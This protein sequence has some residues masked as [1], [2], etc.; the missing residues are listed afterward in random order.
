[1]SLFSPFPWAQCWTQYLRAW[2]LNLWGLNLSLHTKNVHVNLIIVKQFLH[3]FGVC[4]CVLPSVFLLYFSLCISLRKELSFDPISCPPPPLLFGLV[5][6]S[7]PLACR[8]NS[9]G[10]KH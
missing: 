9:Q 10:R 1:M 5:L 7:M 2:K 4:F 3:L 8:R 6:S